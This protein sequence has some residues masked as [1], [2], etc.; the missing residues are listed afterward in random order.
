[1]IAVTIDREKGWF[2]V[3]V[4]ARTTSR[5]SADA[6]ASQVRARLNGAVEVPPEVV[7]D[8]PVGAE[9]DLTTRPNVRSYDKQHHP[10]ANVV[11]RNPVL[12]Q[13]TFLRNDYR[14]GGAFIMAQAIDEAIGRLQAE[15]LV[16]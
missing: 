5:E 9:I 15:G 1:M 14:S 6:L 11:S 7:A 16:P 4:G 2:S 10:D 12:Q 8:R 3:R 13:L